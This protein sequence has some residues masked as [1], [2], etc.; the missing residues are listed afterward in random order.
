MLDFFSENTSYRAH[1]DV[2]CRAQCHAVLCRDVRYRAVMSRDVP[3]FLS[4]SPVLVIRHSSS[5]LLFVTTYHT[6]F[7]SSP[8]SPDYTIGLLPE[9]FGYEQRK[10]GA[11][12]GGALDTV[13]T[14]NGKISVSALCSTRVSGSRVLSVDG[15]FINKGGDWRVREYPVIE[16]LHN[17]EEF[18]TRRRH[19]GEHV[20]ISMK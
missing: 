6:Y 3:L 13:P 19:I 15:Y 11:W 14:P 10:E 5:I 18:R 2:P 17:E 4:L 20:V 9:D 8:L 7:M 1:P 16:S 12:I